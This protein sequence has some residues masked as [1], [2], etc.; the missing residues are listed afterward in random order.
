[1][2]VVRAAG[3]VVWRRASSGPRIA[4]I[5]R[6]R[7]G[8]WSLPKGKLDDG[9]SWEGAALREVEEE[10]GCVARI[11]S[12]AGA[13]SYF[14]RRAPKIVLYWHM[15]LVEEGEIDAGDEV[16][17]VAWLAPAEALAR[18]VHEGE[19]RIVA[20]ASPPDAP[21]RPLERRGPAAA[22]AAVARAELLRR[23]LAL[24]PRG[25]AAGL[26]PALDLLDR[27][28]E[29]ADR[30][31]APGAGALVR[32]ARRLAI[33]SLEEPELSLRAR[34][35]REEARQLAPWRRRAIRKVLAG[36]RPSPEAVYVA[37]ELRDEEAGAPGSGVPLAAVLAVAAA[38]A[39]GVALAAGALGAAGAGA[40]AGVVSGAAA[41]FIAARAGR[42]S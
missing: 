13:T 42:R 2:A 33:L 23:I 25:E 17:E 24:G 26:G 32:A 9:E 16:D 14:A 34:A 27:G 40:A 4:L 31:D 22:E 7:H 28:E 29:L 19:R 12:F 39:A 20:R 15:E 35:L 36:E 11:S 21:A 41:G 10:T 18:L 1:M 5:H 8:D 37:A 3:G 30:G 38:V 6:P